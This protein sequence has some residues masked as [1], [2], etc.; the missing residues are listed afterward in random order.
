MSKLSTQVE[1]QVRISRK[2]IASATTHAHAAAV[3]IGAV[4]TGNESAKNTPEPEVSPPEK[5]KAGKTKAAEKKPAQSNG[6]QGQPIAAGAAEIA[7]TYEHIFLQLAGSLEGATETLMARE[8]EY[9]AEQAD[10]GPIRDARDAKVKFGVT[11]LSRLRT[12]VEDTLG[13]AALRTY[14]LHQETPRVP[15]AVMAQAQNVAKL[16]R[17]TPTTA[18]TDFGST[19]DTA[20]AAT[21]LETLH[22]EL[23]GL[24]SDE[25]R[26]ERELHDAATRRNRAQEVWGRTYQGVATT[27]E[28]LYLVAGL[29]ELADRV[30]PTQRAARGE[31]PGEPNAPPTG[32]TDGPPDATPNEKGGAP[33]GG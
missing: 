31:D 18:K 28:G 21:T 20:A 6:K 32:E 33:K 12:A 5:T 13:T 1:N 24:I 23:S 2:V 10:D 4:L 8:L 25:D 22:K 30:R 16:L 17:K 26:E 27:L 7:T 3:A 29:P 11:V 14:G 9:T 19:F 15:R